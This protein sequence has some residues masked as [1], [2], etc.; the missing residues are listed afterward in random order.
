MIASF[1]P[2]PSSVLITLVH[3][4]KVFFS[5]GPEESLTDL[6]RPWW[7]ADGGLFF[8]IRCVGA[9]KHLK[10]SEQW[11]LR[12]W[13]KEHWKLKELKGDMWP[14]FFLVDTVCWG[15]HEKSVTCLDNNRI[16]IKEKIS[17]FNHVF[18]VLFPTT[19]LSWLSQFFSSH[20]SQS[21]CLMW[22]GVRALCSP[23]PSYSKGR[24]KCSCVKMKMRMLD[25]STLMWSVMLQNPANPNNW[26]R[27]FQVLNIGNKGFFLLVV[28]RCESLQSHEKF[29]IKHRKKERLC[30]SMS[31]LIQKCNLYEIQKQRFD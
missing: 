27:N 17:L 14:F 29:A 22:N 23:L 2:L 30:H 20:P 10:H 6:C 31:I 13:I 12:T 15:T 11:V 7:Q 4:L 18:T 21:L 26:R 1:L 24:M 28:F 3:S 8:W 16:E 19:V 9:Q 25:N 5:P